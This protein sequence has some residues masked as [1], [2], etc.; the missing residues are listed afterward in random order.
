MQAQSITLST[1][2]GAAKKVTSLE[3]SPG[4]NALPKYT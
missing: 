4:P 3:I 2:N 1:A